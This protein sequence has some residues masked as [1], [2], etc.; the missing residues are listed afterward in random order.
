MILASARLLRRLATAI[1]AILVLACVAAGGLAWR[2]AQGPLPLDPLARFIEA[3]V[4]ASEGGRRVEIG[5]A[6]LVWEG[7]GEGLDR[8]I[9]LRLLGIR[10]I[11]ADG[12]VVAEVP[13]GTVSL[14]LRALVLGRIEPR[15]LEFAGVTLRLRR[16][17][18]GAF[19][20]DFAGPPEERGAEEAPAGD[21]RG[22]AERLLVELGLEG[23]ARAES[24]IS[25]LTR[26]R[27]RRGTV[28]V[29]DESLGL[30][31]RVEEALLDLRR[32]PGGGV[33]V[34]LEGLAS[35]GAAQVAVAVRGELSP[36]FAADLVV[37]LSPFR[38]A[39]LA[40][41]SPVLAPLAALDGLVSVSARLVLAEGLAPH[42]ARVD[43]T[44]GAGRVVL[45][46]GRGV[47]PLTS[48]RAIF[49]LDADG[50]KVET[51]RLVLP[52]QHGPSP[53]VTI[54]G[55][56]TRDGGSWRAE[57][58]LDVEG[59]AFADLPTLWPE[60]VGRNERAWITANLTAGVV[61]EARFEVALRLDP[62]TGGVEPIAF[63]GTGRAD[64]VTVHYLRP[65][66]PV[67][68]VA[69]EARFALD[70]I[71]ISARDGV[72]GGIRARSGTI[73]LSGLD[74][75]PQWAELALAIEAPVAEA[76]A[77]LAH[78]KLALFARRG[79]PP[80]GMS[81][82]AQVDL[83]LRF[84]LL[85]ALTLDDL[86]ARATA[87]IAEASLPAA[88]LDRPL[89]RGRF[90]LTVDRD[91]LRLE[92][93]GQ[94]AGLDSQLAY[95]A[96]FRAG[97]PSQV[98]ERALLRLS[99]QPGVAE[100]FGVPLAPYLTGAV[101]G[102]ARL[103]VRRDRQATV[104]LR[105]DLTRA[106]LVVPELGW[107]KPAGERASAEATARLAG[108]RLTAIELTRLEG[109]GLAARGRALFDREGRLERVEIADLALGRTRASGEVRAPNR[110]GDPWV[111]SLRGPLLD[112]SRRPSDE[113][114]SDDGGGMPIVLDA[115]FDRVVLGTE[116]GREL[117]EVSFAL[118]RNG[119]RI[120]ALDTRGRVGAEGSW[121]A[122]VRRSGAHRSLEAEA[123]DAGAFLA[124]LGIVSTMSGGRLRLSGAWDESSPHA[125]L[126]GEATIEEFRLREAPAIGRVLQAMTLYG[127]VEV[128]R[129][130]GLSFLRLVA[131]FSYD[132][133]RLE[134]RDAR[135]FGASLGFTARGTVDL[136][137]RRI[138]VDGTIVPAYAFN[139]ILGHIPLIGR[140]FSPETGGGVFAATYRVRGSLDD[141]EVSVNPLAALTPGFLRGLFGLFEGD[142][143]PIQPQGEAERG[144]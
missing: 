126:V 127:L 7:F 124:T 51:A 85:D 16:G 10:F 33:A 135:A 8:P 81:G 131:P 1:G 19:A 11:D 23:E 38:P 2:L 111:V 123:S 20:V 128:A 63:A 98:I 73:V 115:R 54:A 30:P 84:P 76:I 14:G 130:P 75:R 93:T 82:Q 92:G 106:R 17:T 36:S 78:P 112:L 74:T 109:A 132:G 47:V 31:W 13:E 91:G 129:G 60:G 134:L 3:R 119:G 24:R 26:L 32:L 71:E 117:R 121:Q 83:A 46:E 118:R 114:G 103:A 110:P 90:T 89:E 25:R 40:P 41:L 143:T 138:S 125:P 142:G 95:E 45:P 52:A 66:P 6:A 116:P 113:R 15:A 55:R 42:S 37:E 27:I 35:A 39:V 57:V 94:L 49:H 34:A 65:M 61:R 50:V 87:R 22:L 70:R 86:D 108:P 141:P 102:E 69:A 139:T 12:T 140:L 97:P 43:A 59:V 104:S 4:A 9:D 67:T 48:A 21:D 88:V 5:A 136:S 80:P 68:G 56:A 62:A 28:W 44:V 64:D 77:L 79:P 101:G 100:A 72:L 105:A 122:T 18:D 120:A 29:E 99:P 144:R 133:E 137:R 96:D 58:Q 107:E 53:A